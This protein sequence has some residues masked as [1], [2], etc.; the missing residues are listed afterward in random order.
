MDD[1]KNIIVF[2]ASGGGDKTITWL[3]KMGY[4][5]VACVD[6]NKEKWGDTC[7]GILIQNPTNITSFLTSN[8]VIASIYQAAIVPQLFSYGIEEKRIY[9]REE[10]FLEYIMSKIIDFEKDCVIN[11]NII[12][13]NTSAS[14]LYEIGADFSGINTLNNSILSE[15]NKRGKDY[16]L[17][18]KNVSKHMEFYLDYMKKNAASFYSYDEIIIYDIDNYINEIKKLILYLKQFIPFKICLN[19][20]LY[21]P[22]TY[23]AFIL[24]YYYNEQ[25]EVNVFLHSARQEKYM[26]A[27]RSQAYVDNFL[28][29]SQ[30]ILNTLRDKYN[31]PDKKLSY[32]ENPISTGKR[33]PGKKYNKNMPLHI[34]YAARL[35]KLYKRVDLLPELISECEKIGLNYRMK[36]AGIGSMYLFL[37]NYIK[38]NNLYS[39]V[40]LY[41]LL[42]RDQMNKLWEDTDVFI[43]LSDCEA[44]C[45]SLAESM[46]YG[47]V[48]VVSH[49]DSMDEFLKDGENSELVPLFSGKYG[50]ECD[51]KIMAQKLKKIDENREL[52]F[53]YGEKCKKIISEKC[54]VDSYMDYLINKLKI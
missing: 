34:T 29:T 17:I 33:Y 37:D 51:V 19:F 38:K 21:T 54:S 28:C 50:P 39:K 6:N 53:Q 23:A 2:G 24:K 3:K 42:N 47:A 13:K 11:E 48:P 15:L 20:L 52:L 4:K 31:I 45:L 7:N 36:I 30:I 26:H 22:L 46:C 1:K 41:G 40:K 25:V 5:I 44:Q 9:S 12:K 8:I 10:V 27:V 35:E 49:V 14:L 16:H 43:N 18:W 32:K